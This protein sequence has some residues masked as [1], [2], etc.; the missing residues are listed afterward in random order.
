M[1]SSQGLRIDFSFTLPLSTEPLK[2][3]L[4]T[5]LSLY[6]RRSAT[7]RMRGKNLKPRAENSAKMIS[8]K[9]VVSTECSTT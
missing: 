9:L 5:P 2:S 6:R 1:M 7:S 3:K 8:V 4:S